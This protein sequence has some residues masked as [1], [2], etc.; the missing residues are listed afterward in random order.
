MTRLIT[1][2]I[3][4]L[5][6]FSPTIIAASSANTACYSDTGS[7]VSSRSSKFQSVAL[8]Q[9]TC[10]DN[11]KSVSAVQGEKCFCGDT[12]PSTSAN[13]SNDKCSTVCP[14]YP[15]NSCGGPNAWTVTSVSGAAHDEDNGIVT[16]PDDESD[17]FASLSVNP[18]MVKTATP[19][20]TGTKTAIPSGILTAP[21]GAVEPANAL[22]P[23]AS[24]S[25]LVTSARASVSAS[26]S[27]SPS[28]TPSNGGVSV[29][30]GLAASVVG[31][32]VVP[33]L[34]SWFC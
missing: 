6:T 21:S 33:V 19:T 17:P 16:A 8:C 18:T 9:E 20:A 29:R 10:N 1:L 34:A 25:S 3:L 24:S 23:S 2:S 30:S 22:A 26:A 11:K 5:L 32:V 14:G 12:T 4:S 15:D 13:V 28:V 27:T 7:L 31:V